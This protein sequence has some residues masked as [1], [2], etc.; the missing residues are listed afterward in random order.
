MLCTYVFSNDQCWEIRQVY[1]LSTT[2]G[3]MTLKGQRCTMLTHSGKPDIQCAIPCLFS[4][5][6][7]L[8]RRSPSWAEHRDC[9]RGDRLQLICNHLLPEEGKD[10]REA[11][12]WA[13][14]TCMQKDTQSQQQLVFFIWLYVPCAVRSVGELSEPVLS[15]FEQLAGKQSISLAYLFSFPTYSMSK[16]IF[17]WFDCSFSDIMKPQKKKKKFFYTYCFQCHTTSF[18]LAGQCGDVDEDH[19]ISKNVKQSA[20]NWIKLIKFKKN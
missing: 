3:R 19:V 5:S 4:H 11:L 10:D 18:I 13:S 9:D 16:S 17:T 12:W 1:T 20:I 15:K 6:N 8:S 2:P 14:H 7:C